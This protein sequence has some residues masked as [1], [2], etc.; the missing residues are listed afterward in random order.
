MGIVEQKH[1]QLA[2]DTDDDLQEV[3]TNPDSCAMLGV[4]DRTD[5]LDTLPE[6]REEHGTGHTHDQT[7]P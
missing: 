4:R 1:S 6:G 3:L 5:V 2:E 7:A